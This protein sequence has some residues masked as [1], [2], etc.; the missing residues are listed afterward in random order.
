MKVE[1]QRGK[2]IELAAPAERIVTIPIPMA[3][4]IMALDG[5]A[6]RLIGIHPQ[7]RKSIADG[8]LKRV[9][10][11]AL[12]ITADIVRGGQFN[13]NLESILSLRPDLVVQWTEPADLI[14]TLESAGL[15]VAGLV[16]DPPTQEVNARNL[17]IIGELI[18]RG[19]RIRTL[20]AR[21]RETHARISAIANGIPHE[22]RP[23]VLYFR[24][25]TAS[26]RPASL[27]N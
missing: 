17:T 7:A 14:A 22:N 6:K 5:S 1:D 25:F 23:R 15:R 4:V 2:I 3:A 12:E 24:E 10:P 13:P 9:F 19:D 21:H 18:G 8:F 26:M 11:Q 27:L 20:L 16:N